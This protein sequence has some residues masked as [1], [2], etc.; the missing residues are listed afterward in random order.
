MVPSVRPWLISHVQYVLK[1]FQPAGELLS[2]TFSCLSCLIQPNSRNAQLLHCPSAPQSTW[3]MLA[4]SEWKEKNAFQDYQFI[5]IYISQYIYIYI[6]ES[7]R[8]PNT[9]VAKSK[10]RGPPDP[11]DVPHQESS[12]KVAPIQTLSA[13]I[14][15]LR[16]PCSYEAPT[17]KRSRQAMALF[18]GQ[19]EMP[20]PLHSYALS[21]AFG[22]LGIHDKDDFRKC[23][24]FTHPK[25][26]SW[27][28]MP[29][30][31]LSVLGIFTEPR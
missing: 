16:N 8:S 29:V 10:R 15:I 3:Q 6:C 21:L 14:E 17:P 11:V 27:H 5:Y 18:T 23:S 28:E 24:H 26:K 13:M 20:S 19:S 25:N 7:G 4:A 22:M 2:I 30:H 12:V 9:L 1:D 31:S